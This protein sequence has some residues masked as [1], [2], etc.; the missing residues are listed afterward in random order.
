MHREE[1][2]E[3]NGILA[4]VVGIPGDVITHAVIK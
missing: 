3:R 4:K 2:A 1:M